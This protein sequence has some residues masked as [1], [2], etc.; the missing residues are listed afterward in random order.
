MY[1]WTGA[2]DYES[3][4]LLPAL[5]KYSNPHAPAQDNHGCSK[6]LTI[7]HPTQINPK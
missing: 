6:A 7:A 1:S 5:I 4:T 2:Q 3:H